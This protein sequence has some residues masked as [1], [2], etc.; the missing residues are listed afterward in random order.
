MQIKIMKYI[1]FTI[2]ATSFLACQTPENK[3]SKKQ[4]QTTEVETEV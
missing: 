3:E 1:F 4:T 2:L